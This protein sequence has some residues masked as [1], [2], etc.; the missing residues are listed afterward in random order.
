MNLEPLQTKL[1]GGNRQGLLI[2]QVAGLFVLLIA[3]VNIA[4]CFLRAAP[5]VGY[6]IAVRTAIGAGIRRTLRQF[7]AKGIVVALLGG[8]AW[9]LPGQVDDYHGGSFWTAR[10]TAFTG[11]LDRRSCFSLCA[12]FASGKRIHFWNRPS[13]RFLKR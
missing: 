5:R 2:L 1:I 9:P 7:L 4:I 3:C 6:E 11:N 8:A 10:A 12:L 13:R